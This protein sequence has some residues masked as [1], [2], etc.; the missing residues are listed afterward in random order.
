MVVVDWVL[1]RG[2]HKSHQHYLHRVSVAFLWWFCS[3]KLGVKLIFTCIGY[4]KFIVDSLWV[5]FRTL[6]PCPQK[7]DRLFLCA[8]I[9]HLRPA[10]YKRSRLPRNRRTVNRA[11]GGVLSGAAVRERF[12]IIES[13]NLNLFFFK[14][15]IW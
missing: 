12:V 7:Y 1:F 9:P 4:P 8:Q 5:C 3:W 2:I 14:F 15:C 10:E 11:Y 13:P 6:T